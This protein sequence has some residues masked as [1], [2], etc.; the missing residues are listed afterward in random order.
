MIAYIRKLFIT[1]ISFFVG[2]I[3]LFTFF[4]LFTS[5]S[6]STDGNSTLPQWTS[7]VFAIYW[8][9]IVFTIWFKDLRSITF[10]FLDIEEKVVNNK[11]DSSFFK[12]LSLDQKNAINKFDPILYE[13]STYIVNMKNISTSSIQRQFGLGYNRAARI[14][15][16]LEFSGIV[17]KPNGLVAREVRSGNLELLI[18]SIENFNK[19]RSKEYTNNSVQISIDNLTDGYE[20]ETFIGN[21]LAKN[22]YSDVVVTKSS[23][24]YG[25]D[26]TAT[27]DG[28]KY[29]IQC[30]YYASTVG[31]SSVQEVVAGRAYY[32]AH[33][34]VVATNNYF[35]RN[36]VDLAKA[37]NIILWDRDTLL[38]MIN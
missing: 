37:N 30:K 27:K 8:L 1:L 35:T 10:K 11:E 20:F 12:E 13:V 9:L 5:S 14:I 2:T 15:D 7:I 25:I 4:S 16:L 23:N 32:N 24:D 26:V 19:P 28:I 29:A 31:N 38:S 18:D 33:V 6:T 17:G 21:L 22:N 3:I 36:A 34:G